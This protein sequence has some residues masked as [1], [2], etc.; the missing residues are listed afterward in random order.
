[1]LFLLTINCLTSLLLVQYCTN[2]ST[3]KK[4][5]IHHYTFSSCHSLYTR[6]IC[7][8]RNTL[9][10]YC[11]LCTNCKNRLLSFPECT[12]DIHFCIQ[13]NKL[14]NIYGI[15]IH[16]SISKGFFPLTCQ[17]HGSS[18][19]PCTCMSLR[20]E[21]WFFVSKCLPIAK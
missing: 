13:L 10:A 21:V 2:L 14:I 4:F 18:H 6:I 12:V 3:R 9:Y 7:S 5:G 8:R 16:I 11:I 19:H 20:I 17:Q 1:M 15:T